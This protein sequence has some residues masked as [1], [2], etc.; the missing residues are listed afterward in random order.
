[1]RSFFKVFNK[2][3]YIAFAIIALGYFILILQFL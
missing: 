2:I 1:M 3:D